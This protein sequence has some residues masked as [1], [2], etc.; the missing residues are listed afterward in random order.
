M[1]TQEQSI[2]IN[3][4]AYIDRHING[5]P[6]DN[7]LLLNSGLLNSCYLNDEYHSILAGSIKKYFNDKV[8]GK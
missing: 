7:Q 4:L 1:N 8:K 2:F 5:I 3:R 6:E